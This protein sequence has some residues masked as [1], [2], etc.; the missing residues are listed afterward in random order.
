MLLVT[1]N[2]ILIE[3][4][5]DMAQW[6]VYL[7]ICNLT[8]KIQISRIRPREMMV[9]LISIYKKDSLKVKIEI[10][11]QTLGVITKYKSKCYVLHKVI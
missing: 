10:Y 2:K 3:Y 11:H 4:I 9:D 8:H 1:D 5:E 6:L 7:T